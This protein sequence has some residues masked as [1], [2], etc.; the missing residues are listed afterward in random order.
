M[1]ILPK[2]IYRF[3]VIPIK[4]PMAIFT[5]LE[6]KDLKFIW[7]TQ[8]TP[9]SQSN[10]EKENWSWRNQAQTSDYTIKL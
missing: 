2:V 7:K 3:N 5:K 4:S 10:L 6:Q 1:T 9:D 8:K